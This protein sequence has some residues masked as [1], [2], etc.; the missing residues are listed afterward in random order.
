MNFLKKS[1]NLTFCDFSK[2]DFYPMK[3]QAKAKHSVNVHSYLSLPTLMW[4][5][6]TLILL[7]CG[8]TSSLMKRTWLKSRIK[9]L[10]NYKIPSKK[11]EKLPKWELHN[12]LEC[13]SIKKSFMTYSAR[14]L[15]DPFKI[16]ILF[17]LLF[18]LDT[19]Y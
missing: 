16:A 13:N 10:Q 5:M 9:T 11:K 19:K 17:E 14:N 3:S 4:D 7:L 8:M 15:P 18:L 2:K 1:E 12:F 6:F